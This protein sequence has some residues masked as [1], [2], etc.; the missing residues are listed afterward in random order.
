MCSCPQGYYCPAG[1]EEKVK[2]YEIDDMDETGP[3]IWGY[4]LPILGWEVNQ[5]DSDES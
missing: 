3:F 5:E 4:C 1:K 2:A